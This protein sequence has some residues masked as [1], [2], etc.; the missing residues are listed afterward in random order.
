MFCKNCGIELKDGSKFCGGC[1]SAQFENQQ[2]SQPQQQYQQT[3]VSN[4]TPKRRLVA[5][6]LGI[7]LGTYGVHNFYLGY[8]R[9]AIIQAC[10][11]GIG[12]LTSRFYIGMFLILGAM[13]WGVVEGIRIFIGS[14]YVDGK[15]KPMV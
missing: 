13:I 2:Q 7:F 5:G 12:W 9:K 3:P 6:L 14:I 8:K 4:Q 10:I 15:G 11:G 1:G